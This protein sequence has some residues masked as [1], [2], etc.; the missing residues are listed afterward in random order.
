M[1][2]RDIEVF[3]NNMFIATMNGLVHY[4]LKDKIVQVFNYK[5]LGRINK[6][7]IKTS[8][9]WIGTSQ[10]MISYRYK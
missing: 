1:Q 4:N 2:I 7:N 6:V 3:K 5:F 10:G 9:V 8:K